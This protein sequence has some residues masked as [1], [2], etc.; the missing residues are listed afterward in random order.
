MKRERKNH[1]LSA[2][3]M[4]EVVGG[5]A[6]ARTK[7]ELLNGGDVVMEQPEEASSPVPTPSI[8]E[9]IPLADPDFGTTPPPWRK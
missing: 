3:E 1:E 4:E 5:R 6:L 7:R 9:V 2:N 8:G